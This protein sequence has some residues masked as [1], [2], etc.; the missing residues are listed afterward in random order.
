[1]TGLPT[2][3][4][5]VVVID[6]GGSGAAVRCGAAEA[7][8]TGRPLLLVHVAPPDDSWLA[9]VG[10]D[11]L[12][13]AL[14]RADA[15]VTGRVPVRIASLQGGLAETAHLSADAAVV[16]LEQ[17]DS[18]A[19]RGPMKSPAAALAEVTD[20]P[21]VVVPSNW[22]ERHRGV[23]SVGFDPEAVDSVAVRA[24]ITMARLRNAALRVVV[25]GP[26]S[27]ADVESRLAQL[28]GDD[29]DLAVELASDAPIDA[30]RVAAASSDLLVLGRH[31]PASTGGSRLGHLG[32]ELLGRVSCP[33]MLTVPGHVHQHPGVTYGPEYDVPARAG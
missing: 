4:P 21:V 31:R 1:V 6:R 24:G 29:C 17:L 20:A 14:T 23:V 3:A 10:R 9:K 19:H 16:V 22:V 27:R 33:V 26:A 5:V 7:V 8:R 12:R 13:L 32:W 11:S 28:G 30:L 25:A 18:Q 15:E 2:L